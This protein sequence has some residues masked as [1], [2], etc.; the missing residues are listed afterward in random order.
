MIIG[1]PTIITNGAVL[2][3]ECFISSALQLVLF[4]LALLVFVFLYHLPILRLLVNVPLV[5][6]DLTR[7]R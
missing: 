2:Y 6:D 1:D 3:F 7:Y 5:N 4:N